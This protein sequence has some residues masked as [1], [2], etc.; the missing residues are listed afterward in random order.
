MEAVD[1]L[2]E[3][4]DKVDFPIRLDKLD[5]SVSGINN[6]IQNLFSRIESIERNLKDDFNS[7]ISTVQDKIEK[8]QKANVAF[9]ILILLVT[10]GSLIA[11]L[12]IN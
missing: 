9:L 1:E 5:T 12:L 10:A 3:K 4:F 8:S 7:K 2:L 6:A 11:L